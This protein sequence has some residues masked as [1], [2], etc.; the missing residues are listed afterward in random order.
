MNV[1]S[2]RRSQSQGKYIKFVYQDDILMPNC[3][4][5]MVNLAETDPDIGLVFS[6]REMFFLEQ[7]NINL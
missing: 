5:K 4:E 2:Y 7:E 6:P 1:L 3:I